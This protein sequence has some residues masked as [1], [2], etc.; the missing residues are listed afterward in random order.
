[1]QESFL[2]EGTKP[3]IGYNVCNDNEEKFFRCFTTVAPIFNEC[4]IICFGYEGL[5]NKWDVPEDQERY[6]KTSDSQTYKQYNL[7]DYGARYRETKYKLEWEALEAKKYRE[8]FE[9]SKIKWFIKIDEPKFLEEE[10]FH[11]IINYRGM[12]LLPTTN[13]NKDQGRKWNFIFKFEHIFG[14]NFFS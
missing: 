6:I 1:M 4:E 3:D 8:Q 10:Y 11:S 14:F 5:E 13:A 7:Y 9:K 12:I 2:S